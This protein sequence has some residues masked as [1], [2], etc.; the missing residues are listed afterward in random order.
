M[1]TKFLL[2]MMLL[3][4]VL[5]TGCIQSEAPAPK[6]GVVDT[7]RVFRD[8]EPGK[9]GVKFLEGLHETMQSEL[10][11]IQEDMQKKPGDAAVQQRLQETYMAFQQRMGAE[12]QN[13]ISLL[14]DATQR[15]MDTYRSQ[16][17]LDVLLG[18]EAALSYNKS[19]DVT[20]D[21][22]VELNK[23]KVEF[24]PVQPEEPKAEAAPAPEAEKAPA[25]QEAPAKE[26][27]AKS[28]KGGA[29]K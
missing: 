5:V 22:I 1:R 7:A 25:A 3:A 18:S 27:P 10:N 20:N 16:K 24:K 12:Q 19:V 17:N 28:A 14:N 15:A 29:K 9:A 13:V 8:S 6:V 26:A 4:G 21:V 23:Q 11:A 2:P